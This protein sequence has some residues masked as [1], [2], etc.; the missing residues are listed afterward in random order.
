MR[1][2]SE[3]LSEELC[4]RL[5]PAVA[6][7][8]RNNPA[9]VVVVSDTHLLLGGAQQPLPGLRLCNETHGRRLAVSG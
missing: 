7:M 1:E 4:N 3:E 6:S 2:H 5:T 9:R 8:H